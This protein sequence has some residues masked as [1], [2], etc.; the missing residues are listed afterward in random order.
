[1]RKVGPLALVT[2]LILI[3][4]ISSFSFD[5]NADL[6]TN[7]YIQVEQESVEVDVSPGSTGVGEFNGNVT[8]DTY[9][10]AE[11]CM[12][13]LSA[14]SPIGSVS[15][16]PAG[17][18]FQGTGDTVQPFDGDLIIPLFTSASEEYTVNIF[19]TWQQGG[20]SGMAEAD[21]F[22]IV[23]LPFYLPAVYSDSPV[24]EITQ[25]ESTSYKLTI[26]NSGN[27]DD[28]Y[29]VDIANRE[30]L[31]NNG[32]TIEEITDIA[33][34]E[35]G[36]EEIDLDVDTSSDTYARVYEIRVVASSTLD[37][38]PEET[39]YIIALKVKEDTLGVEDIFNPMVLIIIVVVV[40][41]GIFIYKK[42]R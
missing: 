17:L 38:D 24:K 9:N 29:Q 8:C 21:S 39:E 7:V 16:S 23:V 1:M 13:S 20:R 14:D 25:G 15:L 32:I 6:I 28:I 3:S 12:V 22:Q 34:L 42:K 40:I 10:S 26:N 5:A 19:G 18:I 27:T 30:E 2:I 31:K 11:P 41:V 37:D 35:H 36:A 33:I 4:L